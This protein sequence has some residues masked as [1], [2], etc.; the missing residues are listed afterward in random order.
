MIGIREVRLGITMIGI[1]EVT[2]VNKSVWH[3]GLGITMIGFEC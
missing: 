1:R 2:N 3:K